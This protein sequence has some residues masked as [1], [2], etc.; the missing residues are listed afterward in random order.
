MAKDDGKPDYVT[1]NSAWAQ[2]ANEIPQYDLPA[3][4][5]LYVGFQ[6][7]DDP[8]ISQA[9][10]EVNMFKQQMAEHRTKTREYQEA[11]EEERNKLKE[12]EQFQ[13]DPR[14]SRAVQVFEQAKDVYSGK[15]IEGYSNLT[16][17]DALEWAS[18][19][20]QEFPEKLYEIITKYADRTV[21][22][23]SDK[24]N[25]GIVKAAVFTMAPQITQARL[26]PKLIYRMTNSALEGLVAGKGK[27]D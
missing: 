27:E 22:D 7:G 5:E 15:F 4:H 19:R 16:V 13:V 10:M 23:L 14:L 1:R 9:L 12:P 11:S 8:I 25:E 6:V 17:A 24:G 21:A 20:N 26:L 18:S 3:M 2:L